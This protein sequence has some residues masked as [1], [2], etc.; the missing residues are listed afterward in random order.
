MVLFLLVCGPAAYNGCRYM[1]LLPH[2]HCFFRLFLY[3]FQKSGFVIFS[4]VTLLFSYCSSC[5]LSFSS[6]S[7]YDQGTACPMIFATSE[8]HCQDQ[9]LCLTYETSHKFKLNTSPPELNTYLLCIAIKNSFPIKCTICTE[10]G[11]Q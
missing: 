4:Q 1:A 5:K 7:N 2:Q 6:K 8:A 11:H 9:N 10:S 3:H